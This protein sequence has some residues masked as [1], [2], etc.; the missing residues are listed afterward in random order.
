MASAAAIVA[1]ASLAWV[2]QAPVQAPAGTAVP[3]GRLF[4]VVPGTL[5]LRLTMMGIVGA[6]KTVAV[7]APFDGAVRERRAQLGDHVA[8]GD[9]LLVMDAGE[10]QGRLRDAQAALL[11]AAMIA[12]T[13]ARW[14]TSPDVMRARRTLE[15]AESSLAV[16][17]RQAT[18]TKIL[19]D[20]GIVSRNEYDAL[21]QQRDTQRAM[22]A[23]GRQD[24]QTT[25]ERGSTDNRRL[26]DL[27]LANARARLADLQQQVDGALLVAA[28]AG[29]LARPPAS[30]QA[31]QILPPIEPGSRVT[32]G[33]PLFTIAD[34]A[35]LVVAGKVDE[36]DVNRIRVGQP[37]S[38]TSDAFPGR[39][40]AGRVM[41][42]SSE[43]TGD[44]GTRVPSFDVRAAFSEEDVAR[45][46]KIRLGMSARMTI[47]TRS[48]SSAI[49]VPVEGVRGAPS[50]PTVRIRDVASGAIR[51]QAVV[52]GDT[53]EGGVEIL[54][55]LEAGDVLVIP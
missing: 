55:G 46:Q 22:V 24:Q 39:P 15:A 7:L 8:A 51:D 3:A 50:E 21:V 53:T 16:L 37:A 42:I 12:D 26:A 2:W 14:D 44:Q 43:A 30:P 52:V 9:T 25:L 48:N 28:A 49:V 20:R 35:T 17:E 13:L 36:V 54:R 29:I 32:R 38:I 27:D 33:Q 19:F 47:E 4:T 31:G 34:T 18:E 41:S 23:S 45:R 1:L 6:G 5:S 10:V 11:K 40:I